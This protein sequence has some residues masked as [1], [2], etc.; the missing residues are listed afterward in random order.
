MA[1]RV[2]RKA[3]LHV[4]PGCDSELV[5]PAWWEEAEGGAWRVALRCPECEHR[6]EG[7]FPQATVDAYDEQLDA[8]SE[9][10]TAAYRSAVRENLAGELER[11]AGALQAGAI[12]PEDF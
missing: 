12:L 5:Q 10:L 9:E 8:G 7:V 3:G 1:V 11:F 6:H 4:C 2:E